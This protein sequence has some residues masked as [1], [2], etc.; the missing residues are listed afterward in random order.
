MTNK[1]PFTVRAFIRQS[2]QLIDPSSHTPLGSNDETM[3]VRLLN[4]LL[5]S[6]SSSGLMLTIAKTVSALV[7]VATTTIK[8]VDPSYDTTESFQRVESLVS[9]SDTFTTLTPEVYQVGDLVTGVGISDNTTIQL[10]NA[11]PIS[12]VVLSKPATRTGGFVLTFSRE[13]IDPT[14]VYVKQGRISNVAN[15]WL[16]TLGVTY[17]LLL[18]SK[19]EYL[20]S[21]KYTPSRGLPQM[22]ICFPETDHTEVILYPGAGQAYELFCRGKFQLARVGVNEDMGIV[23]EYYHLYFMYAIAR[24]LAKFTGRSAAWT[25]DLEAMYQELEMAISNASEVNL[26][27]QTKYGGMTAADRVRGGIFW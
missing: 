2:Y 19:D 16:E 3:G 5:Q 10:V 25:P 8:F 15:A 17:P 23:P 24:H 4:Q 22:M 20:A 1:D 27:I 11:A 12:S 13:I 26:S 6:Y 21:Y 14:T 7:T 9:G 18:G